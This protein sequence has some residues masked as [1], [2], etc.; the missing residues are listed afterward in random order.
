[1]QILADTHGRTLWLGERDCSAQRRHQKLIEE[2]PAPK[3][4]EIAVNA[5]HSDG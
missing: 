1:M 2:S 5:A 3:S 4:F